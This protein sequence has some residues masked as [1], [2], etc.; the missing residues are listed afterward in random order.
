MTDRTNGLN[1]NAP[2]VAEK[3]KRRTFD[4]AY[5]LQIV[6]EADRCVEPGQIGQLLRREGLYSSHLSK[7]RRQRDEGALNGL[8]SKKRGRKAKRRDS[9]AADELERLRREKQEI[10]ERLRQA[11]VII[12]V[13]KKVSELLGTPPTQNGKPK[14]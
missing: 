6:E 10:A 8:R 5:R 9:V 14:S 4:A 2:E 3:P 1:G 13:Q 12:E 11:E 7:W